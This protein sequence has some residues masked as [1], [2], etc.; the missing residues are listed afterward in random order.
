MDHP[1]IETKPVESSNIA[2]IGYDPATKTLQV[3]FKG[4]R[5]YHYQRVSQEV[6]DEL[7]AAPSVGKHFAAIKASFFC[8]PLPEED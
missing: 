8:V 4:G 6:F 2:A 7:A 1:K 3:D 5:K